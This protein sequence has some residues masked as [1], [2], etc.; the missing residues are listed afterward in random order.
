MLSSGEPSRIGAETRAVVRARQASAG[1][2]PAGPCPRANSNAMDVPFAVPFVHRL[3]FTTD[4]FGKDRAVLAGVLE[5]SEGR[6]ARVQF[7]LDSNVAAAHPSLSGKVQAFCK[8]YSDRVL[9]VGDPRIVPGG[10]EIKND[11]EVVA[12]LLDAFH[13][14]GL[15]RR[16]Y[17]VVIGGGAVLDAVGF[18]AAIAHRGIRLI[19][20]PT[21]TLA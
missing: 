17:V 6:P 11:R 16:S 15:D 2:E 10:E 18:A 14:A 12:R 4:V 19:R 21:T 5:P 1:C 7:W 8:E 13:S 3:R 9:L 20:L